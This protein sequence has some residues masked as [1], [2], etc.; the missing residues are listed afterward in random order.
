MANRG[1]A[2]VYVLD[3]LTGERLAAVG[4]GQMPIRLAI[5]P[6]G[7]WAATSDL[8][9]G[10]ISIIDVEQREKVRTIEVSGTA[11][12]RQVTLIWSPDGERLYAAE[13]ANARVA[14][15]DFESG[16]VLRYLPAGEGSD[17]LGISPV[18]TLPPPQR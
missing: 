14:E 12:A 5:S 6:D 9:D 18:T 15:I 16:R 4:V 10:A 13:T 8:Q 11:E 7:K 1:S 17:G 3:A 2:S